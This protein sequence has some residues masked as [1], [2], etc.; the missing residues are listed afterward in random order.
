VPTADWLLTGLLAP[1]IADE[2]KN[3]IPRLTQLGAFKPEIM[4]SFGDSAVYTESQRVKPSDLFLLPSCRIGMMRIEIVIGGL[5]V[6][7]FWAT[8]ELFYRP[9]GSGLWEVI[10]LI[11]Q[12]SGA[13]IIARLTVQWALG[14]FK[15]EKSWER[16]TTAFAEILASLR[17]T[18][19]VLDKW[20]GEELGEVEWSKDY[21]NQIGG[22]M[23]EGRGAISG[24]RGAGNADSA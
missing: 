21:K 17:E 7:A 16:Q 20:I 3:L 14:R 11:V 12:F 9:D 1:Q 2:F 8:V 19:R 18:I 22:T 23:A 13:L 4:T 5:L 10:K 6:T 15:T 24:C